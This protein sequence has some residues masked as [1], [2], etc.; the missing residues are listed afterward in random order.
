MPES[1]NIRHGSPQNPHGELSVDQSQLSPPSDDRKNEVMLA[2]AAS[3]FTFFGLI[4]I[5]TSSGSK[6]F[7]GRRLG[8]LTRTLTNGCADA[9]AGTV[10][11]IHSNSVRA[12]L[13]YLTSVI[14]AISFRACNFRLWPV[15]SGYEKAYWACVSC[16]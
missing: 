6:I 7:G 8:S 4:A 15:F 12:S 3:S 14:R 16:C 2:P 5:E 9:N 13:M 10:T 11:A 1:S